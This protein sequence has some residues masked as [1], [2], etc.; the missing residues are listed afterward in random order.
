MTS[1][2]QGLNL[3]T[4]TMP[5]T[6]ISACQASICPGQQHQHREHG[7]ANIMLTSTSTSCEILS[8]WTGH[9]SGANAQIIA[10][11]VQAF[12]IQPPGRLLTRNQIHQASK[13]QLLQLRVMMPTESHLPVR[14][15]VGMLIRLSQPLKGHS[16]AASDQQQLQILCLF[17][18]GA[19]LVRS[20]YSAAQHQKQPCLMQSNCSLSLK[21]CS[22]NVACHQQPHQTGQLPLQ[23]P[24]VKSLNPQNKVQQP[25]PRRAWPALSCQPL[26]V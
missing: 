7:L 14:N 2:L 10:M 18:L 20:L 1:G 13:A 23:I 16:P 8:C 12:S 6:A 22:F 4:D 17:R 24:Q 3:L 15:A 11:A 26:P 21:R 9:A 5:A 25:S 19:G